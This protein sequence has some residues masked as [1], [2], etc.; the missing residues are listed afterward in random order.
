MAMG[1]SSGRVAIAALV[2]LFS[3]QILATKA[4]SF[5]TLYADSFGDEDVDNLPYQDLTQDQLTYAGVN[6]Y[7]YGDSLI[8][9]DAVNVRSGYLSKRGK[10]KVE[11]LIA[12]L[13]QL[14]Q[15]DIPSHRVHRVRFGIG[16]K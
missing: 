15:G 14:S 5:S 2:A 3:C 7:Q 1:I 9:Q 12:R 16:R 8:P 11:D 6:P 13:R 10:H 4:G